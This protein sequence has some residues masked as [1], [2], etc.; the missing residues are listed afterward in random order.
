VLPKPLIPTAQTILP[1]S[2]PSPPKAFNHQISSSEI[3]DDYVF[4]LLELALLYN[5]QL[6]LC[7]LLF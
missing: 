4:F 2:R 7:V 1:M 3:F 5:L 6:A